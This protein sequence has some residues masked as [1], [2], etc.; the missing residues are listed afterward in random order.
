MSV[1]VRPGVVTESVRLFRRDELAADEPGD[2]AIPVRVAAIG[3]TAERALRNPQLGEALAGERLNLDRTCAFDG[4]GELVAGTGWDLGIVLSP[5]KRTIGEFV[6]DTSASAT[7]SGVIDTVLAL[8]GRTL[9][10]NTNSWAVAAALRALVGDRGPQRA[11]ILGSGASTRSALLGIGRA[12]PQA[13]CY[14]AGRD[15]GAASAV[16]AAFGATAVTAADTADLAPDV[17][18][19]ATTWGETDESEQAPFAFPFAALARPGRV[20]F[21][22]N[23]RRS[24]LVAQAL[25]QGCAVMS[26]TLMQR[27]THACR[28]AAVRWWVDR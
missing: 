2:R 1:D 23:N 21:D 25:D 10:V 19:N 18:I 22:L 5:F 12:W 3:T 4:P 9:G 6:N 15:V 11:L 20:F 24:T 8:D 13:T 16:A 27:V 7:G 14:V 17:L 26:G 28:A